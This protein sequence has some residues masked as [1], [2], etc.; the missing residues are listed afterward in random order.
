MKHTLKSVR[1]LAATLITFGSLAGG[2]NAAVT[3]SNVNITNTTFSVSFSG[4]LPANSPS[5]TAGSILVVNPDQFENPG[6]VIGPT[7]TDSITQLFSGSQTASFARIGNASFGDYILLRF[8]S[9]LVANSTFS[10]VYSA[11][12]DSTV[13]DPSAVESLQFYWGGGGN[14]S[15]PSWTV[16]GTFLGAASVPEPTSALLLG[17]AALGIV[18]SRRRIK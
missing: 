3:I 7:F 15:I 11:S 16:G 5:S 1:A 4:T 2:A 6:F 8:N 18:A 12:F 13:F 17:F 14:T 9:N 10:G